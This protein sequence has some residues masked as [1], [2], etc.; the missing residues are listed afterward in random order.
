MRLLLVVF[1]SSKNFTLEW[2]FTVTRAIKSP[3]FPLSA[4]IMV[5]TTLNIS[6]PVPVSA[7]A[8]SKLTSE[9]PA[10]RDKIAIRIMEVLLLLLF[11]LVFAWYSKLVIAHFFQNDLLL[12]ILNDVSH[13]LDIVLIF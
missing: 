10:I 1:F 12:L 3:V 2:S 6:V 7:L 11:I 13:N 8:N 4:P 9:I 5:N